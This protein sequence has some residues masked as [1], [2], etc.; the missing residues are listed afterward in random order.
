MRSA[1]AWPRM[2]KSGVR[3]RLHA[4]VRGLGDLARRLDLVVQHH[5]HAAPATVG[6][7]RRAH[8][9]QKID[10]GIGRQARGR[11]LRADHHHGDGHLEH[12][13]QDPGGFLEGRRAMADDDAGEIRVLGHQ[14]MAQH[15]QL[16]P[17]REVDLGARHVAEIDRDNLGDLVDHR[18][19]GD[20]LAGMHAVVVHAI[21][22]QLERMDAQ[23]G[24]S[25]AG[26]DEGHLGP[27]CAAH[28]YSSMITG[29]GSN[30][31]AT[32]SRRTSP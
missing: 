31:C 24:N 14:A 19:A 29:V 5:Q 7:G 3:K 22:L 6:T 26:A 11:P 27:V 15:R 21:V 25:A 18:K 32:D 23:R 1:S 17:F 10:R 8:A 28:A 16:A 30:S 12:Q 2:P 4:P 9:V 13:V 20:D